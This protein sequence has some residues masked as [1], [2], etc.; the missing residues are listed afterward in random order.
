MIN[1]RAFARHLIDNRACHRQVGSYPR[2]KQKVQTVF[3]NNMRDH[4]KNANGFEQQPKAVDV[5]RAGGD[6]H[7]QPE[8]TRHG[9]GRCDVHN[10][11]RPPGDILAEQV[12]RCR[13]GCKAIRCS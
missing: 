4:R 5:I 7:A 12:L 13:Q 9:Q 3:A 1:I 2:L 6:Q 10:C 8:H 11:P